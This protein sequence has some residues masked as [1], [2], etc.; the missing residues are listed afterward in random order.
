MF[1][2]S[3]PIGQVK[4]CGFHVHMTPGFPDE[5]RA[6]PP[7]AHVPSPHSLLRHRNLLGIGKHISLSKKTSLPFLSVHIII[8]ATYHRSLRLLTYNRKSSIAT[9][10]SP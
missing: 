2:W 5:D 6:I 9:Q 8:S 4:D 1:S 7:Q 3:L 10:E